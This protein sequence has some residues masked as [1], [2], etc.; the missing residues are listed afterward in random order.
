MKGNTRMSESADISY[1]EWQALVVLY[2]N[3]ECQSSPVRYVGLDTT[4]KRLINHHPPLVEWVGKP[5]QNQV[6]ITN[7]GIAIWEAGS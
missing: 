4:I 7:A 1:L 5:A 6:H 2:R 3:R